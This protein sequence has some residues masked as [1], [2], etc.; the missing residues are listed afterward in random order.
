[1]DTIITF[2][3][4]SFAYPPQPPETLSEPVLRDISLTIKKGELV[5]V[6]G[7]NGSGKSTLAK[8]LG[9]IYLPRSGTVTV[10]G[11]DTADPSK[12]WDIRQKA[13]FVFQNPDNQ[14]VATVVEE[15]VAFALENLGVPPAEIRRRV[16][17]ALRTVGMYEYREHAPHRLSG[18]QKQ[19]IAVAG[20]LAMEPEVL[21]LDE[22]TAMLDPKGRDEVMGTILT[23]CR[24]QGVTIL[25]ITHHMNEAALCDRVV[26]MDKGTIRLDG[27]PREVFLQADL[28]AGLGLTVP[29]TVE[30][31][32]LLGISDKAPLTVEECAGAIYEL[33][34]DNDSD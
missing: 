33:L 8:L 3:N 24:E 25:L 30:L 18:G 27:L 21:I 6:L 9:G 15:D 1:M 4:V 16:D 20:V 14:I 28:L 29:Q 23:L 22:P 2:E 7:H 26:L 13:G 17:E 10:A 31:A 34:K 12:L 32:R 19:R 5:A 11:M